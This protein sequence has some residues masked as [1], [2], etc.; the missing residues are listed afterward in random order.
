[1]MR[2]AQGNMELWLEPD[3]G[4]SIAGMRWRGND[5]MR[6]AAPGASVL[7]M[8]CFPLLP[9]SNRI[10]GG[11]FVAGGMS[12]RL[13][14]NL[15][16]IDQPHAIHGFGWQ[17]LW[18]VAEQSASEAVLAHHYA[19]GAWPWTYRATQRFALSDDGLLLRLAI[20]NQASSP[21][22]AGLGLHPYFPR[23]GASVDLRVAGRWDSDGDC[24]P[25]RWQSLADE[26]DWLGAAPLDHVF[27]GRS[28]PIMIAWPEWHLTISPA[29][30]L[31][32]TVVY[33]PAGADFFCVEPVSHMTDAV[34]RAEPTDVT[35]LRWLAPDEI[36]ET[37]VRFA[38]SAA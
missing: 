28:G 31:S 4:G 13:A 34:N 20:Q 19:P 7:G 22:P 15:P 12:V 1:M 3:Q 30:E 24:L 9:F 11:H 35:G 25:T 21:M 36:W 26:P 17:A 33:A 14:P 29:T 16:G 37:Q 6:P 32:F 8:A 18:Q 23:A 2:L 27:T 5:I 10:A 38:V